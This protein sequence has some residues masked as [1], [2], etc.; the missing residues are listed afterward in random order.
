MNY[1][2]W[3]LTIIYILT[4]VDAQHFP[5]YM[6]Y[7][8][9]ETI[10]FTDYLICH[11]VVSLTKIP[12][13]YLQKNLFWQKLFFSFS[14]DFH[15]RYKHP[16][17]Q[18]WIPQ[19]W[20]KRQQTRWMMVVTQQVSLENIMVFICIS[21]E[22]WGMDYYYSCNSLTENMENV[23]LPCPAI[24]FIVYGATDLPWWIR[25]Q[26]QDKEIKFLFRYKIQKIFI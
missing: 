6:Q 7:Q 16:S 12:L 21:Q 9:K 2:V 1:E 11:F 8:L 20:I 15:R 17:H 18:I 25:G 19:F 10:F 4:I 26:Q 3:F 13:Q 23:R 24:Q 5:M 14:L 22:L